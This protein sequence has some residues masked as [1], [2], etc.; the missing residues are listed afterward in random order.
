MSVNIEKARIMLWTALGLTGASIVGAFG[1]AW[2]VRDV[3]EK[4]RALDS[5]RWSAFDNRLDALAASAAATAVETKLQR[6]A[7]E[8]MDARLSLQMS[9]FSRDLE[10][11]A[12]TQRSGAAAAEAA[13]KEIRDEVRNLRG[14]QE[15]RN[16]G[17]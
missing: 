10:T 14:P 3:F 9:Y 17:K 8:A 15:K 1:V 16:D 13:R 12:E 6:A 11:L 5:Q 7:L 4:E 2:A